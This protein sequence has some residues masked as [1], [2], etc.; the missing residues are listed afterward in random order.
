MTFWEMALAVFL[1]TLPVLWAIRRATE[2]LE[3]RIVTLPQAFED[4]DE[5][6]K[7]R[8]REELEIDH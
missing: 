1:G 4:A 6:R 8:L 7:N 2:I 5:G 3:M